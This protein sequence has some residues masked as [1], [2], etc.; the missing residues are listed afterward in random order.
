MG[1]DD[2]LIAFVKKLK[3]FKDARYFALSVDCN[4]GSYGFTKER[5]TKNLARL[6]YNHLKFASDREIN[7]IY[8][9]P[10][11][12]E[13]FGN[14]CVNHKKLPDKLEDVEIGHGMTLRSYDMT[15]I[16]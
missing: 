1:G 7:P 16:D 15:D 5:A 12:L 9:N 10:E 3:D 6:L 11:K 13:E 4:I 8:P 14:Y 2:Y